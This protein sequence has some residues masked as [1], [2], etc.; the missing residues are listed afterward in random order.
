M[1]E[2]PQ[3]GEQ[4]TY[5]Q[6]YDPGLLVSIPRSHGRTQLNLPEALWGADLWTA[7]E[8]SW[9]SG[10]GK[11]HAAVA[12]FEISCNS[13]NIVESK[14]FKL[15]LNSLNMARFVS[16][17]ELGAV[18]QRDL[19][20]AI[21]TPVGMTL[22]TV[23]EYADQGLATLPGCSLDGL[24]I[25][26]SVYECDPGLLQIDSRPV[27]EETLY[28]HLFRSNCPVTGQPDWASIVVSY[29][30]SAISREGL[31]RYLVSYRQHQDFHENCVEQ[32][33]AHILER[34]R[35]DRLTVAARFTRRGGLDIN[36]IRS[37]G[38]LS[39]HLGRLSRQ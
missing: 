29:R 34:C 23:D 17:E 38:A 24:D 21:G 30:G 25:D 14:S 4:T 12:E 11:P 37:T 31:L 6:C 10:N 36:P 28:S 26:F 18:L 13:P 5:P 33:F 16:E 8:L 20:A 9:L 35:P 22:Y 39:L 7:Y 1:A 27:V 32:I 2:K 19:S 15:Y 3:L